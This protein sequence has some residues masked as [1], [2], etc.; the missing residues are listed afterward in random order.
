[1]TRTSVLLSFTP[2]VLSY[3]S[4]QILR[5]VIRNLKYMTCDNEIKSNHNVSLLKVY[6]FICR[7]FVIHTKYVLNNSK[8]VLMV[9]NYNSSSIKYIAWSEKKLK[10]LI[11]LLNILISQL[12]LSPKLWAWAL[13]PSVNIFSLIRQFSTVF[14]PVR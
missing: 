8:H 10:T 7:L 4:V 12:L 9:L 1:M 5:Y 13:L 14:C 2:I 6:T 11:N 3:F